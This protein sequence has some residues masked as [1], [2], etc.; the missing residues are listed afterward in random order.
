[1]QSQ[2]SPVVFAEPRD[3]AVR[4]DDSVD[5]LA[6]APT[7]HTIVRAIDPQQPVTDVRLLADVVRLGSAERR[8]YLWIIGIFAG[9]TVA[10]GAFGLASV[11]SYVISARRQELTLR[12]ALGAL[13]RQVVTLVMGEC[14]VLVGLGLLVGLVGAI[15]STR[16]MRAWL[17]EIAPVDPFTLTTVSLIFA[18]ICFA[19]CA[20][21][22]WC[23]AKADPA[24]ALRG[25]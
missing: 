1:L 11:M 8:A 13:P 2:G 5:P 7:L 19:G 4:V 22:V 6:L 18:A 20:H 15:L 17:F 9:L 16:A 12:L 3:L 14:A 24:A 25:E 21:P 23:A 10:L